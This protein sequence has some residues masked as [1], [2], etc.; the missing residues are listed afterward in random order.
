MLKKSIISAVSA[1]ILA[2]V[3]FAIYFSSLTKTEQARWLLSLTMSEGEALFQSSDEAYASPPPLLGWLDARQKESLNG[4]WSI[5]IDPMGVGT[6]GSIFGGYPPLRRNTSGMT[7]VEYDFERAQRIKVPGDVNTQ[8]PR[9][10]FYRDKF[11]LYRELSVAPK[12]GRRQLL[13]FG[14]ANFTATVFLNGRAV[15]RHEGGYVPFHFDVTDE[16]REGRNE[17]LVWIDNRLGDQSIPTGRTDW[18]PYGGL[19]RDVYL[20]EVP[21]ARIVNAKLS[22]AKGRTD[23]IRFRAS[24]QGIAAGET[25]RVQI[26]A[27]N[28]DETFRL[29]GAGVAEGALSAQPELWSPENPKLYEVTVSGGGSVLS[30]RIGFRQIETRGTQILLNGEP[31]K[32]RGIST[33][34]EPIGREGV[35]HSANDM[36]GLLAEAKALGANFVRA[37]HYPY[38]RHLARLADEMGLLLWEEIP[39]YWQIDWDNE[40]TLAIARD[41][42]A[43]LVQRD[44]N[45]ASVIIWSVANETPNTRERLRFLRRL[46]E[47]TRGMDDSRLVS[48]AL[49]GGSGPDFALIAARLAARGVASADV[50]DEDR[51]IFQGV[52]DEAG[53][54]APSAGE[55]YT[56]SIDDPLGEHTD[57]IA[58]NEYFGWYYSVLFSRQLG[59]DEAVLRPL[60]LEFMRDLRF[61][62]K[63]EKPIHISEFGAGAKRGNRSEAGHIWSE[64]YQ[65]RVYEAQLEM[66]TASPQVQGLSP[67]I[68]KDF[69]AMLRPLAGVQDY[70]NRKGLIDENGERKA[71]FYLMRDFYQGEW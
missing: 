20:V 19:T 46:I 58:Y 38:N 37:A 40:N 25:V 52:L 18:W 29:D 28:V 48:A 39:V 15:G 71:A 67:W 69:R 34:E 12:A 61:T 9:L 22:L 3:A 59:I 2:A 51:K 64:D 26:G 63:Y 13:H 1:T 32:L 53:Y 33:H 16:L 41:Q 35:A 62:S 54:F 57:I 11:W 50:P 68:L 43:R 56:L 8:D 4:E 30:E 49:L 31:I 60:M 6:P 10:F 65:L 70:Y 36:R 47:D 21:E 42:M 27:L 24:A 23:Q 55:G 66:L 7:L 44:W 45:R 17:L 14:A 5:I